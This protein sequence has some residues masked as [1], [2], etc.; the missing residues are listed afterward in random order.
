LA[1]EANIMNVTFNLS[2]E[3][4]E[5]TTPANKDYP[6]HVS[7]W[8]VFPGALRR[9]MNHLQP[10]QRG[11]D[12]E[13]I[14][15]M[16]VTALRLVEKEAPPSGCANWVDA[17]P[18]LTFDAKLFRKEAPAGMTVNCVCGRIVEGEIVMAWNCPNCG[19][20]GIRGRNER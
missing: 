10:V 2:A 3:A 5:L 4:L 16:E 1:Q 15:G 19:R 6:F 14:R 12:G 18:R 11:A 17:A 13:P 9:Y 7:D 8:T 20:S